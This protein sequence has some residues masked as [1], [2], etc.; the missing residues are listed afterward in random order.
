VARY[1]TGAVRTALD[2]ARWYADARARIATHGY[3]QSWRV[4]AVDLRGETYAEQAETLARTATHR[5]TVAGRATSEA[6]LPAVIEH[7]F[8]VDVA[9]LA[10]GERF[11]GLTV[12][13][14]GARI[15]VLGTSF[16]PWRQRFALAHSLYH[17][18]APDGQE[19]HLDADVYDQAQVENPDEIRANAFAAAFLLPE[20]RLA[21]AVGDTNMTVGVFA[22]LACLLLVP[23]VVL[24]NRLGRLGLIDRRTR[25]EFRSISPARAAMIAR[26]SEDFAQWAVRANTPRLPARLI[27]DAYLAYEAGVV[28]LRPY[29]DLIGAN[30]DDLR[31]AFEATEPTTRK[32]I[33]R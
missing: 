5:V 13:V 22:A 12:D 18:L 9:V 25:D 6:D 32:A 30:V 19:V 8:G 10:L 21:A 17:L 14:P 29:A 28:T 1:A 27:C 23:P 33:T 7:V 11:D 24:A 26:R 31:P 16:L 4:K 2:E 15:I 3:P 20:D